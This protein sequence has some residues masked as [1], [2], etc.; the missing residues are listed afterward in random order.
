MDRHVH[1]V[2]ISEQWVEKN[3]W[4]KNEEKTASSHIAKTF[5]FR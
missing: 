4:K 1:Y 2:S 5:L 3:V